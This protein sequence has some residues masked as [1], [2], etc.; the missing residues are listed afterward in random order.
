[1]INVNADKFAEPPSSPE[2]S[3]IGDK[4]RRIA[5]EPD[6]CPVDVDYEGVRTINLRTRYKANI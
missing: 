1:M 5:G 3:K 6:D 2:F 4:A